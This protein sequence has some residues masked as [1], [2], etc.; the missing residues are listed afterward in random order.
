ML[1]A[2]TRNFFLMCIEFELSNS[3]QQYVFVNANSLIRYSIRIKLSCGHMLLQK[4]IIRAGALM[5]F[6]WN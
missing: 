3:L 4:R 2:F 6:C 5:A 1:I